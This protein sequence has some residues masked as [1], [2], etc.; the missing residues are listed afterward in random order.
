MKT[1]QVES[2]KPFASV[3]FAAQE[4]KVYSRNRNKK[5]CGLER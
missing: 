5:H 2:K 1:Y 3:E 4:K